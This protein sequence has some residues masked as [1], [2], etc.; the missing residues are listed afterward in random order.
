MIDVATQTMMER[1]RE[2]IRK[3]EG[4][5]DRLNAEKANAAQRASEWAVR[6]KAVKRQFIADYEEKP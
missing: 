4:R 6:V 5:L 1:R 2:A 3:M